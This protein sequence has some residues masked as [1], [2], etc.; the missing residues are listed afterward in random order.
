MILPHPYPMWRIFPPHKWLCTILDSQGV[1]RCFIPEV[2][3]GHSHKMVPRL[4]V[5]LSCFTFGQTTESGIPP[6]YNDRRRYTRIHLGFTGQGSTLIGRIGIVPVVDTCTRRHSALRLL[7]SG[8][9]VFCRDRYRFLVENSLVLATDGLGKCST[10]STIRGGQ[11]RDAHITQLLSDPLG[12]L[13]T[14]ARIPCACR[15]A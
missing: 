9:T 10:R 6:G 3:V 15:R 4:L 7:S 5:W 2:A 8:F 13:G 14:Y 1:N 11:T 12:L